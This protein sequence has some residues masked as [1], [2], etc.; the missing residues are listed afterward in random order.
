MKRV[1]VSGSTRGL[2]LAVARGLLAE[3]YEVTLHGRS[4]SSR[5]EE[6]S[7]ALEDE[8]QRRVPLLYCDVGNREEVEEV[9]AR[10]IEERGAYYGIVCN[11]G[12]TADAAFP[13]MRYDQWRDVLTTNLDSLYHVV[14]PLLMPMIKLRAGGRIVF[15]SSLSGLIGN[16]GQVNYS[17]AKAGMIGAAKSLARELASRRITVNCIAPG[18]VS[19]DMLDKEL[20]KELIAAIPMKRACRPEEVAHAVRFLFHDDAEYMTGQTITLAGG[21]A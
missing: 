8:F 3:G 4:P 20:E 12:V 18:P 2:G 15:M 14:N 1:F 16:R 5:G 11:A 9:L 19:T 7:R 13:A 10:D 21:L 17:A 6:S